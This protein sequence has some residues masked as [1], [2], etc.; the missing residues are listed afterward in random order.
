[1]SRLKPRP[2]NI[3]DA[4]TPLFLQTHDG[5][6]RVLLQLARPQ[7][8]QAWGGFRRCLARREKVKRR[9]GGPRLAILR[10]PTRAT[11][12][13]LPTSSAWRESP[14]PTPIAT[15]FRRADK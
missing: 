2:T 8:N 11:P 13:A 14:R 5:L 15:G 10:H 6:G 7:A 12:N 3:S 1:M 4:T 9:F